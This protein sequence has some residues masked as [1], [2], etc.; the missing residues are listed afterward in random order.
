MRRIVGHREIGLVKRKP[1]NGPIS[2]TLSAHP[3]LTFVPP[4]GCLGRNASSEKGN[5]RMSSLGQQQRTVF[6]TIGYRPAAGNLSAPTN[7]EARL[8]GPGLFPDVALWWLRLQI[9]RQ[10]RY[11]SRWM[12]RLGGFDASTAALL[13]ARPAPLSIEEMSVQFLSALKNHKDPVLR[14]VAAL[15]LACIRPVD[16]FTAS[17]ARARTITIYWDRDP[18]QVMDA[19]DR[20]VRLP[21]SEPRM[22]YVLRLGPGVPETVSCVRQ[23]LRA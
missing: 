18:N 15:E 16:P 5:P 9:E 21:D 8:P 12:K 17:G 11:T 10:C 19:L 6:E 14:A 7:G 22:R 2:V 23:T 3:A 13:R 4:P 20:N 1:P